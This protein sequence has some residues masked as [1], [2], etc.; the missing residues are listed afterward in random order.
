[1]AP[2][3]SASEMTIRTPRVVNFDEAPADEPL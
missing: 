1:M 2:I 3:R